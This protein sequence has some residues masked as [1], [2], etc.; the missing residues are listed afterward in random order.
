MC[1]R[2]RAVVIPRIPS[3]IDTVN[4]C[5]KIASDTDD[6]VRPGGSTVLYFNPVHVRIGRR[7]DHA[8]TMNE[9]PRNSA[10]CCG[11]VIV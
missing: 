10:G 5:K 11:S 2:D 7:R 8:E 3:F 4:V 6:V 1:I 9:V